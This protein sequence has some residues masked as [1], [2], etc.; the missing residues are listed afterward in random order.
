[1]GKIIPFLI[2][3]F[4]FLSCVSNQPVNVVIDNPTDTAIHIEID[5]MKISIDPRETI[6]YD[7]SIGLHTL[8]YKDEKITFD[9]ES[10]NQDG[11]LI[12]PTKSDYIISEE[13]YLFEDI[14][15]DYYTLH[16]DRKNLNKKK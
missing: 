2:V 10:Y 5:S 12:N 14:S 9:L 16:K 6:N 1:M 8:K 4:L 3:F 11:L 7:L 13:F 15:I